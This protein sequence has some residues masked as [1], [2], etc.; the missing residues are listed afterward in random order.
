MLASAQGPC[1]GPEIVG[2]SLEFAVKTTGER[3]GAEEGPCGGF[4]VTKEFCSGHY[5][6]N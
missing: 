4:S 2:A 3:A 5:H 1:G 6:L